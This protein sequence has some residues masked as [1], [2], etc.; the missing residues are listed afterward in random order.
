MKNLISIAC[1]TVL[2]LTP[3]GLTTPQA[4]AASLTF[5]LP[6]GGSITIGE[7][8]GRGFYRDGRVW[9]YNGY[10]GYRE[11]RRGYRKYRGYYFPE[12]AFARSS[13]RVYRD[14]YDAHVAWCYDH[15]KSY[16]ERDDTF[17]PYNGPR[18]RCN[19]PYD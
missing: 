2:V 18:K 9:Y 15:Y 6:T 12:E 17:Q 5:N 14:D 4:Q 11:Y 19:S 10:P 16:R 13:R 1:A 3:I 7:P 8:N